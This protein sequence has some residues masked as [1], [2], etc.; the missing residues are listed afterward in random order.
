[1]GH[2]VG[3]AVK[4]AVSGAWDA[5]TGQVDMGDIQTTEWESQ[6]FDDAW[7]TPGQTADFA[8]AGDAA[9]YGDFQGAQ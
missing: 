7:T 5:Y 9:T 3:R 6:A 8:S 2:K 1:M 4:K